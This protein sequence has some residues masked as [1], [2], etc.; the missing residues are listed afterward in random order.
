MIIR[1][2]ILIGPTT[3][4]PDERFDQALKHHR[5]HNFAGAGKIYREILRVNTNQVE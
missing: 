2:S 3:F 4:V 1:N 5:L